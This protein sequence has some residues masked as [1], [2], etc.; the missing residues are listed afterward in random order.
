MCGGVKNEKYQM[1]KMKL[2]KSILPILMVFLTGC[3]ADKGKSNDQIEDII[4][5]NQP[6]S[7]FWKNATIYFL[8]TDR[9]NNG[10]KNNDLQFDRRHDGAVLRSFEGGDIL[11]ITQKIDDGYFDSLGVNVIWFTPVFQQIKSHTDEG[12]GK[13]YAYHGYWTS[14][15]T[16]L[17]P[18]FGTEKELSDMVLKAHDHGIRVLLDA[19]INHTGPVTPEDPQ[20]PDDWV[21]VDSTCT[22]RDYASTVECTLVDNLPDIRTES[23]IEVK[24]PDVLVKKWQGE[25][26]LSQE[27][28]ELNNYFQ[29]N[30]YP[31]YP[32]YYIVKWLADWVRKMGIDGFRVDTAKH[33]EAYVWSVLKKECE[34]ALNAW[35][36]ANPELV[37]H[38]DPFYM[39]GE[40]YNYSISGGRGYDYGDR[41]VDFFAHGF[42]SLI[43]FEFKYDARSSYDSI[44]TKYSS[45][46]NAPG[47]SDL[48]VLNYL[49]SHDDGDPFDKQRSLTYESANKLLLSPGAVQIYY[50]DET[51]RPLQIEGASGDANLRSM[52]N[53]QELNSDAETQALLRHW[54]KLGQFRAQHPAIG[55]GIHTRISEN[56]YTFA[57]TI[58]GKNN[59]QVI[60]GLDHPEG[61]KTIEVMGVFP[62]G[63]L[64]KDH[65]SGT[66]DTVK[67][68]VIELDTEFTTILIASVR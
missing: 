60:I 3:P 4:Y 15:W 40:V 25:G 49:S 57:R 39:V 63:T 33:T 16:A 20:W 58:S 38:S 61:K 54:Q 11:G 67:N 66:T 17:D 50:G 68:D 34:K 36:Q 10:D 41:S 24:V 52:M 43:N 51:A 23:T 18:N 48:S 56:P 14:D 59:D 2:I 65:F 12:T 62:E 55:A 32:F 44:F 7:N 1:D 30:K 53:W 21:R 6:V 8:L 37:I 29:L 64:I 28:S 31:R 22:Y 45:L 13:T 5:P 9:F 46:L 26:K 27:T 47:F 19:V 42:E 35:R